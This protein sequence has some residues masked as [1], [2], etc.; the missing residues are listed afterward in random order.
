MVPQAKPG[1]VNP[2]FQLLSSLLYES[3]F[4]SQMWMLF[5]SSKQHLLSGDAYPVKVR[6]SESSSLT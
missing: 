3:P 4:G 5:D 1:E 2:N 6:V